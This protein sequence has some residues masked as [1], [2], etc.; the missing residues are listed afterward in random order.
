[1]DRTE[2]ELGNPIFDVRTLDLSKIY[3]NSRKLNILDLMM[4][5][6]VLERKVKVMDLEMPPLQK[7]YQD[8][9]A[10]KI[11]KKQAVSTVVA[12]IPQMPTRVRK[13]VS[14]TDPR[15]GVISKYM[16]QEIDEIKNVQEVR[17]LDWIDN[18]D[19]CNHELAMQ[20]QSISEKKIKLAGAIQANSEYLH[21]VFE[22]LRTTLEELF[23]L[24]PS[25]MKR[26]FGNT[27]LVVKE[28]D[29]NKVLS[30]LKSAV[31]FDHTRFE[32][33]K[34]MLAEINDD[35][36]ELNIN[37]E[38]G[39]VACSYQVAVL[40]DD[41]EWQLGEQRLEKVAITNQIMQT[42][43]VGTR[44]QFMVDYNRMNEIQ[45]VLI[46]LVVD[47]LQAQVN[48]KVDAETEKTIR[49]L[50]YGYQEP[51]SSTTFSKEDDY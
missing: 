34:I 46:P 30:S 31:Q 6:I 33:I 48:Q 35:M 24:K 36:D 14:L 27:E 23:P 49:A 15:I 39:S 13:E 7:E 16:V 32:G 21:S 25:I 18:F 37:I 10:G 28:A 26:M 22:K 38:N 50:A 43:L 20:S 5:E 41:F 40:E 42:S 2:D 8:W 47:R 45:T 29:L 17:V 19:M 3:Y 1:V 51:A 44:N 11:P 9:K 12:E 4:D